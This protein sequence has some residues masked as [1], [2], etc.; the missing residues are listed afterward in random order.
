MQTRKII[1]LV[2]AIVLL[3]FLLQNTEVVTIRFLFLKLSLSR[4]LVV[5]V[6]FGLGA[7][8]GWLVPHMRR[9]RHRTADSD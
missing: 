3:V 5:L 2:V 8:F 4:A 7:L 1:L 6:F 9:T